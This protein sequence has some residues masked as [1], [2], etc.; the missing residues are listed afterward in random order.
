MLLYYSENEF[1]RVQY[2]TS[3]ETATK[4]NDRA[5]KGL[6]KMRDYCVLAGCRRAT[7]LRNFGEEAPRGASSRCIMDFLQNS[8]NDA[9]APM[10]DGASPTAA[11]SPSIRG[12]DFCENR[13]KVTASIRK[14][15]DF[16]PLRHEGRKRSS[17]TLEDIQTFS[18]EEDESREIIDVDH[19]EDEDEEEVHLAK[20]TLKVADL[21]DLAA[22][23][24]AGTRTDRKQWKTL[25]PKARLFAR[26]KVAKT[27]AFFTAR[28]LHEKRQKLDRSPH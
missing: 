4:S 10:D 21:E 12:C 13:D 11:Q 8:R 18:D 19:D 3:C 17:Q 27:P 22:A 14:L 24:E 15:E 9:R 7:I 1:K 26:M 23:E 16:R 5:E 2:L 28:Q 20:K 25:T 6:L